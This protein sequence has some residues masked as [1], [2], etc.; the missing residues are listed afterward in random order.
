MDTSRSV[1]WFCYVYIHHIDIVDNGRFIESMQTRLKYG[2]T[3]CLLANGFGNPV[4]EHI[5]K[6]NKETDEFGGRR[7]LGREAH[8]D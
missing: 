4:L 1:Y 5:K 8:C 7:V 3:D 2:I 6:R